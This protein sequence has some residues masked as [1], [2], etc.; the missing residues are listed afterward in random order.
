MDITVQPL[1]GLTHLFKWVCLPTYTISAKFWSNSSIPN[2]T[3]LQRTS[4]HFPV[5]ILWGQR[6]FLCGAC[7]M[8][9]CLHRFAPGT[10]VSFDNP[11][12]C[13]CGIGELAS[14][15]PRGDHF[16]PFPKIG[17]KQTDSFS[18]S[19]YLFLFSQI[20]ISGQYLLVTLSFNNKFRLIGKM[21]PNDCNF[22]WAGNKF[23]SSMWVLKTCTLTA[24]F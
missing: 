24:N 8:S 22:L 23:T 16:Q 18:V 19:S 3:P 21:S 1:S 5:R 12:T 13:F 14:D 11:K 15:S 4:Q 2:S 6:V 7:V 9:P 20:G 17:G 10:P